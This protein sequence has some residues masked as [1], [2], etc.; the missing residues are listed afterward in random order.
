MGITWLVCILGWYAVY[1]MPDIYEARAKVY[2][3]AQSRLARVMGQ[4][5]VPTGV[6]GRVFIVRQA[7]V[8]RAE[9]EKVAEE[10][11]LN[12]RARTPEEQDTLI[13]GLRER[14]SVIQGRRNEAKNLYTI[15]FTDRDRDTA[16][17]VVN[18]LLTTFVDD[19]LRLK[20][21]G[22]DEATEYLDEQLAYYSGL[23]SDSDLTLAN[24]KKKHVGLLPGAQEGI[25]ERLQGRMNLLKQRRADL[26]IENDRREELRRQ[27]RGEPAYVQDDAGPAVGVGL[28]GSAIAKNIQILED[29]RAQLLLRYMEA[30]PDVVAIQQQLEQ[31]YL[32]AE[33]ERAAVGNH[34]LGMEGVANATNP[35]YQTTLIALNESGVRAA[36]LRS[37]I[38]QYENTI[39]EL[40]GQVD[41]IPKIEAEFR[42]LNRDYAQYKTLYDEIVI[43]KE[44]ERMGNVGED[45][46]V[47][48]FNIIEPPAASPEPIAPKRVLLLIGVL[49][50][51]LGAGGGIAIVMH[52]LNPV[53]YDSRSLNEITGRPVI[54]VVSMSWTDIQLRQRRIGVGAF[55]VATS[56]LLMIFVTALV[57]QDVGPL[58]VQQLFA[59]AIQ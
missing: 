37:Q 31:L 21:Q 39:A 34:G 52:Q 32:Q 44:R 56:G 4:V 19:V 6:G 25:F 40:Q 45:R 7:M 47:V 27:L 16:V 18:S 54:G 55:A 53:F 23:L 9:L 8:G 14:I 41:T 13:L 49:I 28:P 59:T 51:G 36:A 3:D 10:T 2:V 35:V 43:R 29:R 15:S 38:R 17:A 22:T 24:F 46:E 33:A 57:Y 58:F 42:R 48:A 50:L 30:H 11:G 5:G 1:K 12:T 20:G 26:A